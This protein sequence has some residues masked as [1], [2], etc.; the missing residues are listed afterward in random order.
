MQLAFLWFVGD[1][2]PLNKTKSYRLQ[3]NFYKQAYFNIHW[4]IYEFVADEKYAKVVY[5]CMRTQTF[6]IIVFTLM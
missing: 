6:K 4:L 2:Q 1:E 3:K 5:G